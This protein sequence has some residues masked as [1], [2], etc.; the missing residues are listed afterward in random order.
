[1]GKI[2]SYTHQVEPEEENNEELMKFFEGV[3]RYQDHQDS[4][5]LEVVEKLKKHKDAVL[6]RREIMRGYQLSKMQSSLNHVF[7]QNKALF[8]KYRKRG[9]ALENLNKMT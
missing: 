1:M 4:R 6:R 3:R 7:N 8:F 2:K 9:H 5:A